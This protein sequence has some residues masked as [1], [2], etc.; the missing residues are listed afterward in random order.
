[1]TA[2]LWV[3]LLLGLAIGGLVEIWGVANPEMLIRFA[4]GD[5]RLFLACLAIASGTGAFTLFGLH[6]FGVPIHWGPKPFY[7]VGV[8][9]GGALF[10][11]GLALSGYVP[12]TILMALAEGRRDA[13][14]ALLGGL[15]GAAAWTAMSTTAAGH[16]LVSYAN[17]GNVMAGARLVGKYTLR[18]LSPGTLWAIATLYGLSLVML[19]WTLPR[20]RMP[21][22][23]WPR[24]RARPAYRLRDIER[25]GSH[26]REPLLVG[27]AVLLGLLT[28]LGMVLHQIF[29]V[30]TTYS[31]LVGKMLFAHAPYSQTVFHT[32]GW[33]PLSDIGLFLGALMSATLI[34]GRFRAWRAD[35]PPSWTMRFRHSSRPWGAAGGAFLVLFGARMAGGCASGHM[36]SGGMQMA[37]SGW[38]FSGFVLGSMWV[39]ARLVYRGH[40]SVMRK[41]LGPYRIPHG[42]TRGLV[43]L[44]GLATIALAMGGL[45]NSQQPLTLGAFLQVAASPLLLVLLLSYE[46]WRLKARGAKA[47]ALKGATS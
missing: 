25:Y 3:G 22:D 40:G 43:V 35:V 26:S 36:L 33:E 8:S 18:G 20:F 15:M 44:G 13:V 45:R 23:A 12:G 2:P 34:S 39:T 38:V 10:G 19:A 17:A 16:W 4:K 6:Y 14:W 31:W 21:V 27:S 47:T 7:V 41:H 11:A 9:L 37:L 29:G 1:M 30:S 24:R 42:S 46:T 32:V 28:S 5:D